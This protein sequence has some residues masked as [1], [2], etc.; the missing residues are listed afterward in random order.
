MWIGKGFVSANRH[1]FIPNTFAKVMI[2]HEISS[3]L[4]ADGG[5]HVCIPGPYWRD[6]LKT[7]NIVA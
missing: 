5:K 6:R 4:D 3:E 1:G 7:I 2:C